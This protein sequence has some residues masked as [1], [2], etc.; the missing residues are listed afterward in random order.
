[1]DCHLVQKKIKEIVQA[2]HVS[3]DHQLA[4]ILIKSLGMTRV[5]LICDKLDMYDVY[6]PASD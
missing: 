6:A 1:M 5:E 2:R 3:S 4:N